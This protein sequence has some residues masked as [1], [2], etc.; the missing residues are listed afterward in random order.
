MNST[1]SNVTFVMGTTLALK[2]FSL[3]LQ[4]VM[5]KPYSFKE[6]ETS[7][8]MWKLTELLIIPIAVMYFTC[9]LFYV[10]VNK[11]NRQ[12]DEKVGSKNWALPKFWGSLHSDD[13]FPDHKS[14]LYYGE[15]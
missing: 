13:N 12:R 7:A 5:R 14:F 9:F 10:Y 1:N 2:N 4:S 3:E 8:Y 11:V 15:H 6:S